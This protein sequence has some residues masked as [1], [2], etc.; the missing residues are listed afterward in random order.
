MESK[1]KV[2]VF[3]GGGGGGKKRGGK[4]EDSEEE[5]EELGEGDAG[6]SIVRRTR[7]RLR[8]CFEHAA[9]LMQLCEVVG[10][11]RCA[12]EARCYADAALGLLSEA[13]GEF[14]AA[15]QKLRWA[16]RGY[17]Q[18][19][20]GRTAAQQDVFLRRS[21]DAAAAARHAASYQLAEGYDRELCHLVGESSQDSVASGLSLSLSLE[22]ADGE[23]SGE[24]LYVDTSTSTCVN[25]LEIV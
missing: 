25:S 20:A 12:D 17:E 13:N 5:E 7:R 16:C 6:G 3:S 9:V 4:V 15:A 2:G 22:C 14:L 1:K 19:A 24:S 10:D 11:A 23:C 21:Q 8:K 18:L